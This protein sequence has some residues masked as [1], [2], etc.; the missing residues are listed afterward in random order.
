MWNGPHVVLKQQNTGQCFGKFASKNRS[1]QKVMTLSH[2]CYLGKAVPK[3][4]EKYQ[5]KQTKNK[6][7]LALS[8]KDSETPLMDGRGG[9]YLHR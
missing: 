3:K 8:A 6:P 1:N 5:N 4:Q 2:V 7:P 9:Q